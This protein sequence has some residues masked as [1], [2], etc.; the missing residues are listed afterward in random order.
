MGQVMV[1]QDN[2]KNF[3]ALAEEFQV[4][5]LAETPM[6]NLHDLSDTVEFIKTEESKDIIRKSMCKKQSHLKTQTNA[7]PPAQT[8][9]N[10]DLKDGL[11]SNKVCTVKFPVVESYFL[12]KT[13]HTD[14]AIN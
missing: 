1:D 4:Q 8:V 10:V 12:C 3:L 14:Q 7:S 9:D 13:T 5:G 2:L 11:L 6:D